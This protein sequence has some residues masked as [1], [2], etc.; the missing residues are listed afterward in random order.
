MPRIV[1]PDL[2]HESRRLVRT[3]VLVLGVLLAGAA[4]LALAAGAFK[5]SDLVGFGIWGGVGV[6]AAAAIAGLIVWVTS[7]RA[8]RK[9]S[10]L[11]T[12]RGRKPTGRVVPLPGR[13]ADALEGRPSRPASG[14]SA[15]LGDSPPG[16]FGISVSTTGAA[17]GKSG[18]TAGSAGALGGPRAS[19]PFSAAPDDPDRPDTRA[20]TWPPRAAIA[21]AGGG[22]DVG[23]VGSGLGTGVSAVDGSRANDRAVYYA[24]LGAGE[25][26]QAATVLA[27]LRAAGESPVWCDNAQRRIEHL[28]RRG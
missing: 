1:P 23:D 24:A 3:I 20:V 19:D 5:V 9:K 21:D 26:D 13:L 12:P 14:S 17:G 25:L 8:E 27:R 7:T 18:R 2:E 22:L 10:T 28:R 11:A 6:C 4:A 16:A 15:R